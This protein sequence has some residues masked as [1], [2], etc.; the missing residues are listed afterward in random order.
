[1]PKQGAAWTGMWLYTQQ[2]GVNDESEI[3]VEF[4]NEI[5]ANQNSLDWTGFNHGPSVQPDTYSIMSNQWTWRPG[6]DFASDYHA[7]QFLWTPTMIYKYVDGRLIKATPFRWT[8]GGPAQMIVSL[9]VG[10]DNG[11]PGMHPNSLSEFPI[12]H[13]T[14][15]G[16]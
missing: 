4:I 2:P 3:D 13:I 1:V 10:T 6:F 16:I 9:A 15:W 14:I 11:M 7:Y 12:D 5:A 8:S